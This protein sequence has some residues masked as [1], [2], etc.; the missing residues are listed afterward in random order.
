MSPSDIYWNPNIFVSEEPMQHFVTPAG[1]FLVEMK[2]PQKIEERRAR[3]NDLY[4]GHTAMSSPHTL[5][6]PKNRDDYKQ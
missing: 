5:L 6:G 4:S 3:K 2:G 1:S